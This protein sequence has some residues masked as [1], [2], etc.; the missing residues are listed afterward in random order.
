MENNRDWWNNNYIP[1]ESEKGV[2]NDEQG[3]S[4]LLVVCGLPT[5]G[6]SQVFTPGNILLLIH[7]MTELWN[8]LHI[9]EGSPL[10]S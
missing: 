4:C 2:R 10:E 5:M 8:E 3:S 9:E 7:S 6:F 1:T